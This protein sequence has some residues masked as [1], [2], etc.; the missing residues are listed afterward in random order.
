[1]YISNFRKCIINNK[2]RV[3]CVIDYVN[4]ILIETDEKFIDGVQENYDGFLVLVLVVAMKKNEDIEIDGKVSFKLYYNIVNHIMPIIKIIHPDFEI[5]K[6]KVNGFTD[7]K[8]D[9]NYGVGCGLSCGVDSLCCIEDYYFKQCKSYKLTHLTNFF[10]GATTNRTV[11]EN[12]LIN[13]GNYIDEIGLDFMQ[14]NTN[15]YKINNL[16]HQ[17]FHTLRNLSIP[18]FFQKLFNKYYYASSFSYVNSKIIPGSQSITSTEPILI[19]FLS[20]ENIEIILHGAQYSRLRK[21]NIISHNKLAHK[22]L[23]VCVHPNYYETIK[24]KINC[25]KCFKCLRTCA[26][27]DYYN[28]L[29]KFENVF[30]LEIYNKYKKE[31]LEN[32]DTTNPYDRELMS[33][34]YFNDVLYVNAKSNLNFEELNL[35][36]LYK[37]ENKIH[38]TEMN[39]NLENNEVIDNEINNKEVNQENINNEVNNHEVNQENINNEVNNN[40]VN[41]ENINNEINN[42]ENNEMNNKENNEEN[43][44]NEVNNQENNEENK[45][46]KNLEM[47]NIKKVNKILDEEKS[48]NENNSFQ[49]Y[50][51]NTTNTSSE[52]INNE[53]ENNIVSNNIELNINI[54]DDEQQK[55]KENKDDKIK[56]KDDKI[57]NK[58][59]KIKNKDEKDINKNKNINYDRIW[60][61]FKKDWELIVKVNQIKAL[62]DTI[63]KK[64]KQLHSSQLNENEKISY[65]KGKLFKLEKDQNDELY[66][67]III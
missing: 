67:K 52:L 15:F 32:L 35:S 62:K 64:N 48:F 2:T 23:D 8:F 11:Y 10:A 58:D 54:N 41:E 21:T 14:V 37:N 22:Y 43:I 20:T 65:K 47:K 42:Q 29:Y 57:K 12:K 36:N 39:E 6:I 40:E 44:N 53:L 51:M 50:I 17:Y 33:R 13:I 3:E 61:A 30:D 49:E 16:E 56:N 60:W 1:M 45:I 59:D 19:P 18:L 34:Y 27:L 63:V 28:S 55:I 25:S 66:F 31:Y 7:E 9:T 24:E 4:K 38:E 5:I 46:N 26:T